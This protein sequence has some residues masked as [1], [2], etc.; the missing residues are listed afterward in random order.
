MLFGSA[1]YKA[2]KGLINV[3]LNLDKGRIEDIRIEGDF[4]FYP[5]DKLWDLEKALLG[6]EV[7]TGKL[8]HRIVEFYE[9]NGIST[10]GIEPE[11]FV[12]AIILAAETAK[13]LKA[14]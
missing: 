5:E 2:R 8:T 11:D 1:K 9:S 13:P 12:K 14:P 10:P 6:C 4:F 7:E 3:K